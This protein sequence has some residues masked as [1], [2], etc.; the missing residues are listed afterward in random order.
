MYGLKLEANTA[1]SSYVHS[2]HKAAVARTLSA[3]KLPRTNW[4]NYNETL[5]SACTVLQRRMAR[6]LRLVLSTQVSG[7]AVRLTELDIMKSQNVF[8]L[9]DVISVEY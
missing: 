9:L 4:V 2:V 5:N 1:S 7:L 6:M 3:K 8:I